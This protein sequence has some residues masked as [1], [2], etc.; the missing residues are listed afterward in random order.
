MM[1]TTHVFSDSCSIFRSA[2]EATECSRVVVHVLSNLGVLKV[3]RKLIC[4]KV[5]LQGGFGLHSNHLQSRIA[6]Y[7]SETTSLFTSCSER[8]AAQLTIYPKQ[9]DEV[10]LP[11]ERQQA[12]SEASSNKPKN[13]SAFLGPED[14]FSLASEVNNQVDEEAMAFPVV[15]LE[16]QFSKRLSGNWISCPYKTRG[17]IHITYDVDHARYE[18]LPDAWRTLNQQFELPLE[19]VFKRSVNGYKAKQPAVFEMMKTCFLAHNGARSEGVFRLAPDKE[20]CNAIKD[21][22][23][24]GSYEDCS[25][26]H[27][28]ASLIKGWFRELP[29]SLFNML[30]EQLIART[31]KLV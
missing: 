1:A 2:T 5:D 25:D 18:G 8:R 10:S 11:Q 20:E 31:C 19:K 9:M 29:A 4:A 24:D 16:T 30:P 6:R 28:M 21:D 22:I 26:V 14:D 23:N 12:E 3:V 17:E 15:L 13:P 27:I 7:Q